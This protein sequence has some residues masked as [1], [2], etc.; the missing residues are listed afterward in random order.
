VQIWFVISAPLLLL[1]A[2]LLVDGG[3]KTTANEQAAHYAAEAARAAVIAV[4][5]VSGGPQ[6]DNAAATTAAD[7]YLTAAGVQGTVAVTGPATVT[8]TVTVHRI[9]PISGVTFTAVRSASARLLVG[10]DTGEAP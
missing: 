1:V 9:G 7:S 6:L 3:A 2:I 10:V 5:P 4:G 8:V